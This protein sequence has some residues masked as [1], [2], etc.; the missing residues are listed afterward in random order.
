GTGPRS[1]GGRRAG[2][3]RRARRPGTGAPAGGPAPPAAGGTGWPSP[4]RRP[5]RRRPAPA[6]GGG[7]SA[8]RRVRRASPSVEPPVVGV[9]DQVVDVADAEQVGDL[10]VGGLLAEVGDQVA[11]FADGRDRG[12]GERAEGGLLG[13][14]QG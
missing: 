7:G 11:E 9:L 4:G 3:G 14:G 1:G 10:G 6:A 8:S 12:G 13:V 2:P 5:G